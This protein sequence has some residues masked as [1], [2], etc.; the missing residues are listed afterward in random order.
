MGCVASRMDIEGK[1]QVCK[2][3]KKL[4]K[5]LVGHRGEFADAQ[6]AYLRAL[7]N[8]GVTLRQFTES[9][10]LELENTSYGLILPSSPPSPLRPPPPLPSFSP[11]PRNVGDTCKGETTKEESIEINQDGCSSPPPPTASSSWSYWGIFES[12]SPVHHLKQSEYIEPVKE[13]E[14]HGQELVENTA[15]SSLPGKLHP[16]EIVDDNSSMM[17]CC[18]KD[19]TDVAMVVSKNRKKLEGIVKELDDYFLKA[20]AG[21]KEIVVFTDINIGDNS[22][23]WKLND[24]QRKRSNSAKVFSAL[25]W[26]WSFKSLQFA[27][28]AVQCASNEPCKPGAHC[29]TL[30]KLYVAEQKFYKEVKDEEMT[31]L[32]LERKLMLLQKQDENHEWTKTEKIRSSVENLKTHIRNLQQSISTTYSSVLELIDEELYPQ[33]LALTSGLMKMWKMMYKSHQVQNHISQQL[34]HLTDNLSMDLTSESHRQ[35][36]AQLETAVSFWYHGLCKLII[37]QQEYVTTLCRWIKLTDCLVDEH[38]F[39]R[40]CS[41]AVRRLCEEWQLGCEKLPDKVASEAI[42]NFLL[43]IQSTIQQQAEEHKQQK[44]CDKL[45]ERLQKELISLTEMERKVE[46]SLSPKHPLWFKRSKTEA[47]KKRVEMEKGKYL[48]SV[49]VC[50]T[51]TLNNLKTS[52]PN[53]FEALMAFS[54]A[55]AEAFEAIH[56]HARPEIPCNESENSAN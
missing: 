40:C 3:R 12:N 18:N 49:Q 23:P 22:L 21:G 11:D 10:F 6:L 36:T 13:D 1:L 43:A 42:K 34:N 28:D 2:E 7:N 9:D 50:K 16:G 37:S 54:K 55:S 8:T 41:S 33:L 29:I 14:D 5:Q 19:S 31:K 39:N 15:V 32:E 38:Q 51:M 30:N 47:L 25:S 27:G 4:M 24:N 35:A 45:E 52:L 46:G 53:V 20:S 44:K 26:S 56:G 48:N 17:S